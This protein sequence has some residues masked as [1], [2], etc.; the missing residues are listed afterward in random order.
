[1]IDSFPQLSDVTSKV[2]TAVETLLACPLRSMNES[3]AAGHL[4]SRPASKARVC[5]WS[6]GAQPA[7]WGTLVV[8]R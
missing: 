2:R 6:A 8:W 5:P 7:L 4:F 3:L 1:M